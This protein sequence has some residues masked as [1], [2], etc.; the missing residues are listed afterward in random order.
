V[1]RYFIIAAMLYG[2]LAGLGYFTDGAIHPYL[3]A[4]GCAVAGVYVWGELGG[5]L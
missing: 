3:F 4:W 2:I 5:L 1:I